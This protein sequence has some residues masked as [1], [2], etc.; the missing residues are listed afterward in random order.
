MLRSRLLTC[1]LV[2][3]LV[4]LSSL[5]E[6][7]IH[8]EHLSTI[9]VPYSYLSSPRYDI[10]SDAVEQV[11]YDALEGFAYVIGDDYLQIID[12]DNVEKPEIVYK[13]TI[14][15]RANDIA[16]CG[17]FVAYLL[18]GSDSQ[19]P[20]TIHVYEKFNR[21]TQEF[22]KIH[23]RVISSQPEMLTFTPDCRKI[24]TADE[25][26]AGDDAAEENFVNPEGMVSIIKIDG[27]FANPSF[28][29]KAVNFNDFDERRQKYSNLGVR[30]PY[31]GHYTNFTTQTLSQSVEPEYIAINPRDNVAYVNLQENNAIAL[32]DLDTELI[33]EIVPLGNKSWANLQ[34]DASDRDDAIKFQTGHDIKSFYM[35]DAIKYFE[36]DGVG[37]VATADEGSDLDYR[38]D[39]A[40]WGDARRGESIHD[41]NQ[42]ASTVSQALR[43]ALN[44]DL[45][46]GRLEFSVTDGLSKTEEDKIEELFFFGGRGFSILRADD[47]TR[48]YD[49]GDEIERLIAEQYPLVFNSETYPDR[50]ESESPPD[51][52][53]KRSDNRGPECETIEVGVVN[54][55]TVVF[56]GV[57]RASVI[58]IYTVSADG[59]ATY[60]SLHRRGGVNRTFAQLLEDRDL[61]DLDPKDME[62][63]P[64]DRSPTDKPLLMVAGAASGTLSLYHVIGD[65]STGSGSGAQVSN[66][67]GSQ[68]SSMGMLIIGL[69][70]IMAALIRK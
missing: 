31:N 59:Q 3:T 62:F 22:T 17:R 43:E 46:L 14:P 40:Y 5:T 1:V 4:A 67:H 54:G 19:E 66:N 51:I 12:Y 50:P 33:V 53:D 34:L 69:V 42:L 29:F 20:G 41:D 25:G 70:A 52:A 9:Y 8:L 44:D 18:Q 55:K 39:R 60:E 38:F 11:A 37:Y 35:P 30:F 68:L 32:L 10:D 26:T 65:G 64:A 16:H 27:D 7:A 21:Q 23:E 24:L 63:V 47:L 36:I 56:L 28:G 61:G 57:D 6:A 49:S 45:R 48:V 2:T 13:H 58:A 15:E